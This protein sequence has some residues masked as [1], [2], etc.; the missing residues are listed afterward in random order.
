MSQPC[1]VILLGSLS[2]SPPPVPVVSRS[3]PPSNEATGEPAASVSVLLL[4]V[5]VFLVVSD[6]LDCHRSV[7]TSS[8]RGMQLASWKGIP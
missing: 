8:A 6:R 1:G 3:H 2:C 5:G 7:Q 4:T